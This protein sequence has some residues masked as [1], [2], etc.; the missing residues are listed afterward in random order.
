MPAL[1]PGS[2]WL[3][4]IAT[5]ALAC[6]SSI[7]EVMLAAGPASEAI[8]SG[9]SDQ[10][11]DLRERWF[12]TWL[13]TARTLALRGDDSNQGRRIRSAQAS[14][15]RACTAYLSAEW[16]LR[17]LDPRKISVF[18]EMRTCFTKL[19]GCTSGASRWVQ[20]PYQNKELKGVLFEA[21][22]R[23]PIIV[24]INGTHSCMEWPLLSGTVEA[25]RQRGLASLV[26]DHPGSGYARYHDGLWMTGHS[27]RFGAAIID[28]LKRAELTGNRAVGILGVSMGGYHAPRIASFDSRVAAAVSW[29]AL[30]RI[31]AW[32]I[33]RDDALDSDMPDLAAESESMRLFD[34]CS[35][36][37]LRVRMQ[38]FSLE[39]ALE[40]VRCP[41]LIVHGARDGQVPVEQVAQVAAGASRAARVDTLIFGEEGFGDMHINLDN[42]ALGRESIADW[43]F[44]RFCG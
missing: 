34:A 39:G 43:L 40:S 36:A 33:P 19:V 2:Y 5:N 42:I 44:E 24:H 32:Q 38:E 10:D 15:W 31:P 9:T 27:E 28:F 3:N 30:Y 29:G 21:G 4:L 37:E 11:P 22:A 12:N 13:A 8:R 18:D 7:G 35:R 26:I 23:A 6:G 1:I 25:L 17:L 41:L 16:S 20:V 14:Y